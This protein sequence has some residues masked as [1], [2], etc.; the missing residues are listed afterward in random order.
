MPG[1][2]RFHRVIPQ[3]IDR[4]RGCGGAGR[5]SG[6]C[7]VDEPM[8]AVLT[9][10]ARLAMPPS[11]RAASRLLPGSAW[12]RRCACRRPCAPIRSPSTM[13]TIGSNVVAPACNGRR[14]AKKMKPFARTQCQKWIRLSASG[15]RRPTLAASGPARRTLFPLLR[16]LFSSAAH[17]L[18]PIPTTLQRTLCG[19]FFPRIHPSPRE[20]CPIS[21]IP[22]LAEGE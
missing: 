12:P 6:E 18:P 16:V 21:D 13:G 11:S 17:S 5:A 8:L 4:G 3:P 20:A 22:F 2:P 14:A 7:V 10:L 15:L 1:V 9:R 19:R